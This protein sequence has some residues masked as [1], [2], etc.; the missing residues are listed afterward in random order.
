[1]EDPAVSAKSRFGAFTFVKKI[2]K[3]RENT[4]ISRSAVI[5]TLR[6]ERCLFINASISK[7]SAPDNESAKIRKRFRTHLSNVSFS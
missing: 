5:A 7:Q 2:V 4:I 6:G 3:R 1:M